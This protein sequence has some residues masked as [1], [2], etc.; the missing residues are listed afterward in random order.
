MIIDTPIDSKTD[1][2]S[3]VLNVTEALLERNPPTNPIVLMDTA[4][5]WYTYGRGMNDPAYKAII[6]WMNYTAID[7]SMPPSLDELREYL[8][9]LHLP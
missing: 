4:K 1:V 2:P 7:E 9:E 6:G 3:D 5:W 8:E